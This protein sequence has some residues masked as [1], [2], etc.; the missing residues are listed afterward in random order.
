MISIFNLLKFADTPH[1]CSVSAAHSLVLP[2]LCTAAARLVACAVCIFILT[3]RWLAFSLA[4]L[5]LF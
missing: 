3:S 5:S 4:L 2:P 1:R